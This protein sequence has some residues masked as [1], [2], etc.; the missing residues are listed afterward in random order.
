ML[1]LKL[2][3]WQERLLKYYLENKFDVNKLIN[4]F[5]VQFRFL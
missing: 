2:N 5:S 4:L 3:N 1:F